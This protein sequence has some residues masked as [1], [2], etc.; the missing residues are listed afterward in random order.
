M[1]PEVEA[2]T[3]TKTGYEYKGEPRISHKSAKRFKTH[4]GNYRRGKR[5]CLKKSGCAP[6]RAHLKSGRPCRFNQLP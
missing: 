5:T 3:I 6:K 2:S 1:M 4:R